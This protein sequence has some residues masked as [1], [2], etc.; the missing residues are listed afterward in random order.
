MPTIVDVYEVRPVTGADYGGVG[1]I[2]AVTNTEKIAE[3]IKEAHGGYA[4][5][6]KRKAVLN[7]I[8]GGKN[9]P[10]SVFLLDEEMEDTV[11]A[12]DVDFAQKKADLKAS[13]LAKLTD[14]EKEALG[15][16]TD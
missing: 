1:D 2:I 14:K 4:R 10:S 7:K 8:R 13:G 11:F 16:S 9:T 5:V 6:K 12:V 3:E 15:I